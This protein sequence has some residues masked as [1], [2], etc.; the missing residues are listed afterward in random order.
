MDN[1]IIEIVQIPVIRQQLQD[2]K[3]DV[4]KRVNDV[5]SLV[6]TEDTVKEI[7]NERAKLTKEFT[8]WENKRK[9]V[10]TAIMSP[11]EQFEFIYK[12]CITEVFKNADAELK[13]KIE[14][15]ENEIKDKKISEVREYFNEYA[16]S[17]F[18][19]IV[20]YE[21][22][23]INVTLS[24]SLKSLKEKAKAFI[25]KI[26]DDLILI[27]T[28]EHNDE[29]LFLYKNKNGFCYLNSSKAITYISEKYKT[30]AEQ[31]AKEEERKAKEQAKAEAV[32]KVENVVEA[33]TPPE[34]AKPKDEEKI[35]TLKFTVK[36]TKSQ[37]KVLKEFLNNGGFEYE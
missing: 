24:A 9:Q 13:I 12:D 7:K 35:Y 8:K 31:K 3:T 10:K 18:I 14:T 17:K 2:I 34:I 36:G 30:M 29:I 33:L 6:C 20:D 16:K 23:N 28:Q 27:D 19:E 25:D 26:V 1:Q 21:D 5:L 37:L 11:Y 4:T 22:A 32:T 15:V